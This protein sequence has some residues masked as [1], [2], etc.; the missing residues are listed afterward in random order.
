MARGDD[1]AL[2]VRKAVR[3]DELLLG[4]DLAVGARAPV[5]LPVRRAHAEEVLAPD[6]EVDLDERSGEALRAPP[7]LG[8]LR[9]RP[10]GPHP[11]AGRVEHA[12]DHE[13]A[14]LRLSLRLVLGLTWHRS[15]PWS[16]WTSI[17]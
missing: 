15:S 14:H 4:H 10:C 9:V 3:R 7:T 13:L 11:L 8:L 2:C 6:A 17:S 16:L 5:V 12:R 1:V